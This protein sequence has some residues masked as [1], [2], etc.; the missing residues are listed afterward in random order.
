M[1]NDTA[2]LQRQ[3]WFRF[4]PDGSIEFLLVTRILAIFLLLALGVVRE[5]QRPMVLMALA[6]VL[7]L[8]YVLMVWWGVQTVVDLECLIE[9]SGNHPATPRESCGTLA[10]ATPG[11]TS[12]DLHWRRLKAALSA[13]LPAVAV[14]VALAPWPEFAISHSPARAAVMR[15]LLPAAGAAF[16][17]LLLV[18]QRALQKIRMGP[19]LWT[20]LLL[21]PFVHWFAMHRLI[22]HLRA[23]LDRYRQT[24]GEQ[25]GDG[26]RLAVPIADATWVLAVLPWAVLAVRGMPQQPE[27]SWQD[28]VPPCGAILTALFAVADVAALEGVQRQ[29][30][31]ALRRLGGA[32]RP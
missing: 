1:D 31:T 5:S 21:V 14:F 17:V 6:V 19:P 32:S 18:G 4:F 3:R 12:A 9:Q 23:R 27:M 20:A 13:C 29:F 8:D 26:P 22:G 7:L 28:F 2:L 10:Y 25:P 30:V 16:I 11:A 24:R 15:V